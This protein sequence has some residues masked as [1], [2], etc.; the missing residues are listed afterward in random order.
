MSC[1]APARACGSACRRRP[2]SLG[3]MIRTATG[4]KRLRR[5]AWI[6]ATALLLFGFGSIVAGWFRSGF[7]TLPV[8][9]Q[10]GIVQSASFR[11]GPATRYLVELQVER[12]ILKD[13]LYCLLGGVQFRPPCTIDSVVEI[14]WT[15]WSGSQQIAYGSSR[16]ESS[17]GLGSKITKTIGQFEGALGAEY[18]LEVVS[19]L[20]GSALAAANPRIVVGF[21]PDYSKGFFILAPLIAFVASAIAV[22]S[23]IWLTIEVVGAYARPKKQ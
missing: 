6:L 17:M 13:D 5:P 11:V 14:Q 7:L 4:V 2:Q 18:V 9:L 8:D 10:P 19:V 22:F 15:L 20:D 23:F 1:G 16:D 21:P 3:D 12:N